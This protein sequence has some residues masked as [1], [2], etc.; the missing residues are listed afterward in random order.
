MRKVY[1][2]G[3]INGVSDGVAKS[4]R[5]AAKSILDCDCIDPCDFDM[6]GNEEGNHKIIVER[7]K[8]LI[9]QCD[10]LLY[11]YYFPTSG[12][13]MELIYAWTIGKHTVTIVAGLNAISPWVTYHTSDFAS[14]LF[15]ARD[16]IRSAK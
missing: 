15:D 7:D 11:M 13:S 16:K 4:W 10:S 8:E 3:P 5:D 1:L 6:R 2:C 12:S 9:E 14:D